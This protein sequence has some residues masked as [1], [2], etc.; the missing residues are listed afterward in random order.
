MARKRT[1]ATLT[2]DS[3]VLCCNFVNT[4]SYWTRADRHDYLGSYGDFLDWCRKL[5][6]S[7][8]ERLDVLNRLALE[9]PG[10]AERALHQIKEIRGLLHGFISAVARQDEE[11]QA[12]LLPAVNRLLAEGSSKQ[13]LL[14]TGDRF[15]LDQSEAPDD[16]LAPVWKTIRSLADLLT[17][18]GLERIKECPRCGW[19][20]L[21]ETK[22]GRRRWCNPQY[23]GSTDKMMRYNE[24]KRNSLQQ[25]KTSQ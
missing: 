14:Y 6:V 24:R 19:V 15:V 7:S 10:E 17:Q 21:D 11:E 1:I 18:H 4:V 2:I 23:C 3:S 25:N 8:P 13:R 5:E 20:F 12:N 16:L 9:Q 22:N